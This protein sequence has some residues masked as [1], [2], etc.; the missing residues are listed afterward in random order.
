MLVGFIVAS[1][2]LAF[3]LALDDLLIAEELVHREV[4][5]HGIVRLWLIVTRA[6]GPPFKLG[7]IKKNLAG[8]EHLLSFSD[9]RMAIARM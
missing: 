3:V 1:A 2:F 9:R 7:V 5:L 4:R 8:I 6:V